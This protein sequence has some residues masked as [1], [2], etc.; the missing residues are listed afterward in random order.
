MKRLLLPMVIFFAILFNQTYLF[1][2]CSCASVCTITISGPST[3]DIGNINPGTTVCVTSTGDFTGTMGD[4]TGGEICVSAGGN[5]AP[6]TLGNFNGGLINNEGNVDLSAKLNTNMVTDVNNCGTFT[7]NNLAI[8]GGCDFNNYFNVHTLGNIT[9][10]GGGTITNESGLITVDGDFTNNG[11]LTGSGCGQLDIAGFSTNTSTVSGEID[12][13]DAGL[14]LAGFDTESGTIG[15]DVTFCIC[16]V[17]PLELLSF[18]AVEMGTMVELNW[19]TSSEINND[20][21]SVERS[22]DGVNWESIGVKAGA[23]NSAVSIDYTEYDEN[24]H[25]GVSYYR[26]K[27]HDFDGTWTISNIESVNFEGI[28][29]ITA[30]PNP[31]SEIVNVVINSSESAEASITLFDSQGKRIKD[32]IYT[33]EKG[34]STIVLD[35]TQLSSGM[36]HLIVRT[37]NQ[38]YYSE[39]RIEVR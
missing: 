35:V 12:V 1:G 5:F 8:N 37:T 39:K 33:F 6:T 31:G 28:E 7:A 2:Q 27:Q 4:I 22:T 13:C 19:T 30:Y 18:E 26:I 16:A 24:P 20:Y 38:L 29:I 34:F 14:P 3:I 23:G 11:T 21:F 10:N 9:I 25:Q 17:L 15:P 32:D 36:Y